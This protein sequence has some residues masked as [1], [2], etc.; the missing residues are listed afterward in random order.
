MTLGK[1]YA[2]FGRGKE[3]V[4]EIQTLWWADVELPAGLAKLLIVKS[5][6]K[7][8]YIFTYVCYVIRLIKPIL[9]LVI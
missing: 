4:Q 6:N 3:N 5:R 1:R 8:V 7:N 9:F 2:D